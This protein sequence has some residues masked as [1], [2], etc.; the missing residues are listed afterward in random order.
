MTDLQEYLK[1][2]RLWQWAA[3]DPHPKLKTME[4]YVREFSRNL[5]GTWSNDDGMMP[6]PMTQDAVFSE[7]GTGSIQG[8]FFTAYSGKFEWRERGDHV[9]E[10]RSG[11]EPT[12][13]SSLCWKFI[14]GNP[15]LLHLW[16]DESDYEDD[17]PPNSDLISSLVFEPLR[18]SDRRSWDDS[19]RISEV[20]RDALEVTVNSEAAWVSEGRTER[21]TFWILHQPP[22]EITA[23]NIVEDSGQDGH[24]FSLSFVSA[25]TGRL[26]SGYFDHAPGHV[27][28]PRFLELAALILLAIR[29]KYE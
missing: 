15:I 7:D 19:A 14:D 21:S 11:D 28:R 1:T 16:V 2:L 27:D 10:V 24:F 25:K 5:V 22:Y 8:A 18:L 20:P 3:A 12:I 17:P 13:W 29:H 9:I 26:I 4:D 23:A 6:N